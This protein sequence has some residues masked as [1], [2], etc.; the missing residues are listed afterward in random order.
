M[1]SGWRQKQKP[2]LPERHSCKLPESGVDTAQENRDPHGRCTSLHFQWTGIG[3]AYASSSCAVTILCTGSQRS[4]WV[5]LIGMGKVAAGTCPGLLAS[6][7]TQ[8]L[9]RDRVVGITDQ[10]MRIK[11]T[12]Q[13]NI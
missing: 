7:A 1:S 13:L 9:A 8:S 10:F 12:N 6:L 2:C 11:A 3:A 5:G 4:I